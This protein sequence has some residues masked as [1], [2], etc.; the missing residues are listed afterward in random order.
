M[1]RTGY[2][3]T[4]VE[5]RK[6]TLEWTH[7]RDRTLVVAGVVLA[8]AGVFWF[9]T[10]IRGVLFMV[11]VSIFIAVAIEPPVHY[12]AKRGWRRGAATGVVFLVAALVGVG[13]ILALAPLLVRQFN[14]LISN[15]PSYIS[16]VVEF[17]NTTFGTDLSIQNT[18]ALAVNSTAVSDWLSGHAGGV[19]GGIASVAGAIA[20]FFI[21][22]STVAIFSFYI[23]ADLPQLQRTVLSFM[24][25]KRQRDALHVWDVAVEKMGGYV[26]SRLILALLSATVTTLLLSALKVPFALSLGVWV[27]VLSQFIPVVGTYLAAILPAIVALSANG[28]TTALWVVVWFV[29]YQQLENLV[30]SPRITRRTMAIHPAVSI[31]AIIIGGNL[32][33]GIG[34]VLALPMTGI[35]QALISETSRRH[36]VILDGE[37]SSGPA[38][39]EG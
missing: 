17:L 21:F 14:Q 16:S 33:G 26:Y 39:T 20:G 29:G 11:F 37:S 25:E 10:Q 3:P 28:T 22:V 7:F 32:M 36:A 38:Q 18:S 6:N 24:P 19:V 9:A 8:L 1:S 34:I 23:V 13:F 30:F 4:P 31:A 35:I 2:H 5:S 15:L 12:L 27:G